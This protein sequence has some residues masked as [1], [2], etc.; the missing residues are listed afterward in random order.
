[1]KSAALKIVIVVVVALTL[2]ACRTGPVYNVESAVMATPAN[3]TLEQVTGAIKRAGTGLG[4]QMIDQG[5]G[6]IEGKLFLRSHMAVV[7]ITFDTKKFSIYYKDSNN[8]NY[9]GTIIHKNYN[10][11]VQNLEQ[12]ILAE[13]SGL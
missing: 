2:S 10:G 1:M 6:Q 11:W 3:A 7:S 4:W 8:L 12:R 13:T 9:D 5:P